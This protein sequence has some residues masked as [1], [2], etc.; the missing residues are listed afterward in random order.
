M[1]G[2]PEGAACGESGAFVNG[3]EPANA[4]KPRPADV[5]V[6]VGGGVDFAGVDADGVATL[7]EV[8][9]A[10]VSVSS[11][12]DEGCESV[13]LLP[14]A[15]GLMAPVLPLVPPERTAEAPLARDD[16]EP[17]AASQ[18]GPD[19]PEL[20]LELANGEEDEE[21]E[22]NVGCFRAAVVGGGAVCEAVGGAVSADAVLACAGAAVSVG[23]ADV[24]VSA[25]SVVAAAA[26]GSSLLLRRAPVSAR[27][28]SLSS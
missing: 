17:P 1:G 27:L 22:E 10:A 16:D 28:L 9:E 4:P 12:V 8:E 26:V 7:E 19:A 21:N 23:A 6:A 11:L 25:P 15:L 2:V 5:F 14:R 20:A 24:L 3:R 13:L 18:L